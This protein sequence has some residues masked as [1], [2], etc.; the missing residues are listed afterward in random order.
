MSF[1]ILIIGIFKENKNN[2]M[3][4]WLDQTVGQIV[5]EDYKTASVFQNYGIDFCCN[6]NRSLKE[7]CEKKGVEEQKLI[8]ALESI[9]VQNSIDTT[10]YSSWPIDLLA[11]YIEKKHHRYVESRIPELRAYLGKISK[12]H[13]GNHP[14]LK[15]IEVLFS[16]CAGELSMHMKKEEIVLF[17]YIRKM[18]AAQINHQE[19]DAPHFGS[20]NNPIQMMMHEHNTEGERFRRIAD[21]SGQYHPPKDACN[22]YKVAFSML[23][24][25]EDDLHLHIHLENNILF[26][27]AQALE[28]KLMS[29]DM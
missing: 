23:K 28:Q 27:K 12:V 16:A 13:G 25:F 15:E 21:L 22:T 4:K 1:I 24:E 14:E 20:V 2:D 10:N 29:N 9:A 19:L 18:V 5:V 17:P 7:A 3:S 11:D 8:S 6:G 26:P